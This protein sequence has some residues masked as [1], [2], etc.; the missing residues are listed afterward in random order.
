LLAPNWAIRRD[1]NTGKSFL[2]LQVGDQ[3]T[4]VEVQTGLRNDT[5][6]EILSGAKAGDVVVAPV[7]PSVL[8]R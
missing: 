4:E 5:F 6:S 2:T 7:A 3:V 1:R 8:G